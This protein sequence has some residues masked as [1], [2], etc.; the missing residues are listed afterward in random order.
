MS[1][2]IPLL[3]RVKRVPGVYVEDGFQPVA[4]QDGRVIYVRRVISVEPGGWAVVED[5]T[6]RVLRV[7]LGAHISEGAR[8]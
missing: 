8:L 4:L 3:K 1:F 2:R 5:A 7:R 6:G